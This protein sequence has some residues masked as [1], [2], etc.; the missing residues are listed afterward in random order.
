MS[1]R[2]SITL[3]DRQEEIVEKIMA[4][5]GVSGITDAISLALAFYSRKVDTASRAVP[6]TGDGIPKAK[7]TPEEKAVAKVDSKIAME[8]R[9][10]EIRFNEKKNICESVLGGEVFKD[11]SG[12]NSCKYTV[13]HSD[14]TNEPQVLPIDMVNV[15][16]ADHQFFPD[17]AT[18]FK[19]R[20]EVK[21][22][23]SK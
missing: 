4:V 12:G 21:K 9:K 1:K 5:D 14:G 2:V 10:V 22:K 16:Y 20:P 8:K 18:V 19:K 3:T 23:F 15:G 17:K 6:A 11:A 7:M 13:Y